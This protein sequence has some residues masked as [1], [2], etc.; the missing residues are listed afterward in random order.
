[1]STIKT[2]LIMRGP[3]GSGKSTYI[4]S[5]YPDA[6]ICS[7]DDYLYDENGVYVWTQENLIK[8][9]VYSMNACKASMINNV[10][11]IAIDN[12][13]IY[14]KDIK[15]Y[16]KMAERHGYN[17]VIIRLVVDEK[18]SLERNQH[19]TPPEIINKQHNKIQEIPSLWGIKESVYKND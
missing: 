8:A 11:V 7:A 3:S 4:K 9:H 2:L 12:T 13:N 6:F 1:M 14:I 16:K 15:P 5:H 17:V 19:N 10:N 18:T